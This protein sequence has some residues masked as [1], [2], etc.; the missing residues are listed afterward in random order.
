MCYA[1]LLVKQAMN[2]VETNYDNL[3]HG[4]HKGPV[5]IY[6]GWLWYK[7]FS[8]CAV[9]PASFGMSQRVIYNLAG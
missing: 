7:G 8:W 4:Y 3:S 1:Y 5:G 9:I 2:G 6:F